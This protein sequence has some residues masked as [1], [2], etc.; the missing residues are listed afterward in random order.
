MAVMKLLIV[1]AFALPFTGAKPNVPRVNS[2]DEIEP[3]SDRMV[4]FI[5]SLNT[6]WKVR[7]S[8]KSL[9]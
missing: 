8:T 4:S 7:D 5:N 2:S 6:T 9:V 3:L 1:L